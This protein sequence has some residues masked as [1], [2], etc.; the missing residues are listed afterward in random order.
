MRHA[1]TTSRATKIP[2]ITSQS[3]HM[4]WDPDQSARSRAGVSVDP[5]LRR[6][7]GPTISCKI[8]QATITSALR[9]TIVKRM[10]TVPW[11]VAPRI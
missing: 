8:I 11:L 5:V 9:P 7:A 3:N 6:T 10:R 2:S 1:A 4:P